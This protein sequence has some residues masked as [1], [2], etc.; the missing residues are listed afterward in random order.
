MILS[1]TQSKKL[2]EYLDI[3]FYPPETG[4]LATLDWMTIIQLGY[5]KQLTK[6]ELSNEYQSCLKR[7][8][9][10]FQDA[11]NKSKIHHLKTLLATDN[12]HL[13]QLALANQLPNDIFI[14]YLV[15]LALEKFTDRVLPVS[16][17]CESLSQDQDLTLALSEED[18][19]RSAIADIHNS[20]IM[21]KMQAYPLTLT[22]SEI[23]I[24][25]D[26]A[27]VHFSYL[28]PLTRQAQEQKLKKLLVE[29]SRKNIPGAINLVQQL[30]PELLN[31]RDKDTG[32]IALQ[33]ALAYQQNDVAIAIIEKLVA[34]QKP[35]D[36]SDNKF[37]TPFHYN[38]EL[39][40]QT[41]TKGYSE[42]ACSDYL[43]FESAIAPGKKEWIAQKTLEM[44]QTRVQ[45]E[46]TANLSAHPNAHTRT[47][48]K[49]QIQQI[50][51][52]IDQ[53]KSA[54][55]T[56]FALSLAQKLLTA[57]PTLAFRI[58]SYLNG[59][60]SHCYIS[61]TAPTGTEFLLD[62]WLASLGWGTGVYRKEAYPWQAVLDSTEILFD[63]EASPKHSLAL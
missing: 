33:Y 24:A 37:R 1:P 39:I 27:A 63:S 54:C 46:M 5:S 9:Q 43:R 4:P 29:I 40:L 19:A 49:A 34:A 28:Q 22:P 55:C 60:S 51:E 20:S 31:Q 2:Y 57:A 52:D 10:F 18:F 35:L 56:T 26:N 53:A 32:A 44:S 59:M 7:I 15:A 36:I 13:S 6:E 42:Y 61:F 21:A 8:A 25:S 38:P 45:H 12:T 48:S 17:F 3:A 14:A 23:Q 62:P 58:A 16:V 41:L 11:T 50:A 47:F 30:S